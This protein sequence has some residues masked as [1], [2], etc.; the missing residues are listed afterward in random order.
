MAEQTRER[1]PDASPAASVAPM[2]APLAPVMHLQAPAALTPDPPMDAR[3]VF[4][5]SGV[6]Q[7]KTALRGVTSLSGNGQELT[8]SPGTTAPRPGGVTQARL[9]PTQRATLASSAQ[10]RAY[11]LLVRDARFVPLSVR[12]EGAADVLLQHVGTGLDAQELHAGLVSRLQDADLR[13]AFDVAWQQAHATE[14]RRAAEREAR[15]ACPPG[16]AAKPTARS[17]GQRNT[18]NATGLP[19]ALKAGVEALSGLSLD[20]VRVHYNSAKPGE[21]A[22]LAYAQGSEIHVAPGEERHLPHEAWHIVQQ[23]Q[24]RVRATRR[25][26][27]EAINDDAQLEAEADVM[28][29]HATA[30]EGETLQDSGVMP[31]ASR[32]GEHPGVMQRVVAPV[33]E[34]SKETRARADRAS[35]KLYEQV[36]ADTS[37]YG[38][39]NW[40]GRAEELT[41]L[42]DAIQEHLETAE[43]KADEKAALTSTLRDVDAWIEQGNELVRRHDENKIAF[44]TENRPP[45]RAAPSEAQSKYETAMTSMATL[46]TR[47]GEKLAELQKRYKLSEGGFSAVGRATHVDDVEFVKSEP[48]ARHTTKDNLFMQGVRLNGQA[49]TSRFHVFKPRKASASV[50]LAYYFDGKPIDSSLPPQTRQEYL[51]EMQKLAGPQVTQRVLN[52]TRFAAADRG[53]GQSAA[54]KG[55]NANAYAMLTD[56]P[57]HAASRWEWLHIRGASLGGA[58]TS[59]NL[60]LGTR[61]CNTHMMP[62]EAN[63]RQLAGIAKSNPGRYKGLNATW[64]VEQPDPRARHRYGGI[65][66]EWAL[67]NA[68]GAVAREG[69]ASFSPLATGSVL[70]KAEVQK[71]EK[72]LKEERKEVK[73]AADGRN[74]KKRNQDRMDENENGKPDAEKQTTG[75]APKKRK[76]LDAAMKLPSE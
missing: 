60:V 27:S 34:A 4:R 22:A 57:G 16:E 17:S 54:M 39:I 67:V 15:A 24:G 21:V 72:L 36:H 25:V 2:N 9:T 74:A 6:T 52:L 61:D 75:G 38:A 19:D 43:A 12:A 53:P 44:L 42:L 45:G 68:A 66:I 56:T 69:R 58:T 49:V 14:H 3:A 10:E 8:T 37:V 1:R 31:A 20:D 70:S 41:V 51:G 73:R 5:R 62:F 23:K 40:Y 30:Q 55:T 29:R 18:V 28:G 59:E 13:A 26:E 71:L 11:A 65:S 64:S 63:L 7:R 50:T 47:F 32:A 48:S 33:I 35:I 76:T 46:C